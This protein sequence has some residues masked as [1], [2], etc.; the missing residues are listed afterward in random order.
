MSVARALERDLARLVEGEPAL[1]ESGL[2]ETARVL[3]RVLDDGDVSAAEKASC[4]RVLLATLDQLR[5]LAPPVAKG[6]RIDDLG[7]RREA[8]RSRSAAAADS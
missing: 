4:A 5:K 3:A 7:A 6:D 2:A 8:R 1:A